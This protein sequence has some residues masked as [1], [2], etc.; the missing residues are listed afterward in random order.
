MEKKYSEDRKVQVYPM[1][2]MKTFKDI[3]SMKDFFWV[4]C[5]HD[6]SASL[7]FIFYEHI[8]LV[9]FGECGEGSFIALEHQGPITS[10]A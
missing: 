9:V 1:L 7:N 10:I 5:R 6:R 4:G 3:I 8:G 2:F